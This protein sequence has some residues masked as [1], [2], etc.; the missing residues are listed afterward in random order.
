MEH[1]DEIKKHYIVPGDL[2][3]ARMLEKYTH[4]IVEISRYA[5]KE[6]DV[7]L[8]QLFNE[9]FKRRAIFGCYCVRMSPRDGVLPPYP[10]AT[11]TG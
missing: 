6:E 8:H 1:T 7:L 4:E 9:W 11:H 3:A 2:E 5:F 10:G